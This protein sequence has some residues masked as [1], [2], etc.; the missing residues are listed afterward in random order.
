MR[1]SVRRVS[2]RRVAVRVGR[3]D[4][5]EL[6]AR[7]RA[8]LGRALGHRR[9]GRAQRGG[10]GDLAARALAWCS[11]ATSDA[12]AEAFAAQRERWFERLLGPE[13]DEIP[14]SYHT[15]VHA[16]ALAA[17]VDLHEGSRDRDL[18]RDADRPRLRP[19]RGDEH[20]ARPRRPPAEGAARVRD[21]ERPAERRAPDHP[22][23][24]RAARLPGV[25]ARG[26]PRAPLRRRRPVA[27]VH[28]PPHLARPRAD[29][30]LL[31]HLSRRS[32]ASPAWHA[33]YFG[34]SDEQAAENADA[35]IFLEALLFRRYEAKL[36]YELGFWYAVRRG[37]RH[38][39]RATRSSSPPRP[40][41]ATA[42]TTT[43]PTWTRASTR[44]TT[45]ARGSAP[46]SSAAT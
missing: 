4:R 25:P 44:P 43:C 35:T 15:V 7:R 27:P 36:R 11:S 18:P 38:A 24:G 46:P 39:R 40:A 34:L 12:A 19:R 26:R 10:E 16:P 8:A 41:S 29:R 37:R 1:R 32:R 5:L 9:G 20:Q 2:V 3:P 45:C 33:K 13:R 6:I 42:A 30:D 21:R 28:L 17:R 23:A 22:R 31:V 14:S